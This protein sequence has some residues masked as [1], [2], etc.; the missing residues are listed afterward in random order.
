MARRV[1][2]GVNDGY[3]AAFIAGGFHEPSMMGPGETISLIER[4]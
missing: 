1:A 3:W 4:A 2:F